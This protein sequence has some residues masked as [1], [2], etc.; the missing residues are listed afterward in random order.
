M[1][2]AHDASGA[3]LVGAAATDNAFFMPADLVSDHAFIIGDLMLVHPNPLR[4]D[5]D[6]RLKED[7]DYSIQHLKM[8]GR[9]SR[10]NTILANWQH[11]TNYGGAVQYRTVATEREAIE[12]IQAKHPGWTRLNPRR[13]NELLLVYPPVEVQTVSPLRVEA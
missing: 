4:F 7:L 12:V 13:E 3:P 6:L 5:E 2:A 9:V 11:R 1:M 10:M 8:F